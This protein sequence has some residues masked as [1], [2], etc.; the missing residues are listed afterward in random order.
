[1]LAGLGA[2]SGHSFEKEKIDFSLSCDVLDTQHENMLLKKKMNEMKKELKY[3][4]EHDEKTF[5][6]IMDYQKRTEEG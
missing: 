5:A 2:R 1:M 4:R 6:E 3:L